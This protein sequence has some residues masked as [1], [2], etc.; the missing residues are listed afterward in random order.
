VYYKKAHPSL[1]AAVHGEP[2][3]GAEDA[4]GVVLVLTSSDG[5]VTAPVPTRLGP[6]LVEMLMRPSAAPMPRPSPQPAPK[7]KETSTR[8]KNVWGTVR[9]FMSRAAA[10]LACPS[11]PF[12]TTGYGL[13]A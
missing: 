8:F 2:G 10:G 13:Y 3:N 6:E 9:G 4:G 5:S 1:H 7:A 11:A 12:Y